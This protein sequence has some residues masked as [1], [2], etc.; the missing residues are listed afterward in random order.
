MIITIIIF[1]AVLSLLVFVHELGHFIMAKRSGMG[2]HE[3]GFGFPPRVVGIQKQNGKWRV[4]WGRKQLSDDET[5]YSINAIPLGGF[6]KIMG[7]DNDEAKDPRSF[8]NKSFGRRFLTLAAGVLMNVL[9]AWVILSIGFMIGLPFPVNQ[10]S[11]VPKGGTYE[12]K[13]VLIGQ[14][15]P[16]SPAETAGLAANDVIVSVDSQLITDITSLQEYISAKQGEKINFQVQRLNEVKDIPVDV[17]TERD[18]SQ[19]LVGIGLGYYGILRFDP[20][21][22]L[23]QG[24]KSTAFLLKSIFTGLYDVFTTKEGVKAIG[25]PIKIAQFTGQV[26]DLGWIH[27]LQFTAF[28]SL[29][30]AILNSLPVP[31]LDGGRMMFLIIEK[32]RGRPNNQKFEQYANAIGFM[33]L[34][35]LMFVISVRDISQFESIKNLF[36]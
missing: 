14:I 10:L 21:T 18:P 35:L 30:L 23:Y 31:A 17:S 32:L 12:D 1:I 6:V 16:G 5:V 34:L 15:K 28:L 4:V 22:S 2:V 26:V 19:G 20:I 13:Q 33:A 24:G 9:A 29:N 11:D 3:F 7:E 36:S 25:G 27:L 8:T